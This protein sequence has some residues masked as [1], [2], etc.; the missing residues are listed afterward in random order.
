MGGVK[1]PKEFRAAPP[2]PGGRISALIDNIIVLLPPELAFDTQ[3]AAK[4]MGWVQARQLKGGKA[5]H[6][7]KSEA[8]FPDGGEVRELSANYLAEL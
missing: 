1:I 8:R 4:I 2:V 6:R 5:L 7:S 3:A